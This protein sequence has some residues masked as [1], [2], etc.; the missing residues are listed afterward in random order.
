M[1]PESIH[2]SLAASG[3]PAPALINMGPVTSGLECAWEGGY[4]V[5]VE[6]MLLC[7]QKMGMDKGDW[8]GEGASL[9]GLWAI[10][11]WPAFLSTRLFFAGAREGHLPSVL[12]MIHVKRCTPIPAL[13]FTVR[14]SPPARPTHTLPL[15]TCS[16]LGVHI[17]HAHPCHPPSPLLGFTES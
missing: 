13:L 11:G 5:G 7:E 9:G 15:C 10:P 2:Y 16:K 17:S 12:A 6:E 14:A 8:A 4:L 1:H 3:L